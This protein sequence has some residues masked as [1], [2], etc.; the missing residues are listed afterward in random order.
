[1]RISQCNR[2]S[3]GNY[4]P[5]P[6]IWASIHAIAKYQKGVLTQHIRTY[7]ND[8]KRGAGTKSQKEQRP[9]LPV[10]CQ[11]TKKQMYILR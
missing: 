5:R 6:K 11:K 7:T 4:T 9:V 8:T 2:F 10:Q 1:M 3:P